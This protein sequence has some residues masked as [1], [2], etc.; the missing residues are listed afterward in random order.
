VRLLHTADWH[1][2]RGFHGA[3]L[4]DAHAAVLDHLIAVADAERPDAIVV[5]GDVFDRAYPPL[6]AIELYDDAV[7]RIAELRIPLVITSGNHDSPIRLGMHG[8]V[9]ASAGVHVRTRVSE[10]GK[11]VEVAG[12]LLY[13]L[14]YLDPPLHA[15]ELAAEPTHAAVLGAAMARIAA[16]RARRSTAAPAIAIAHGVVAG[17]R[18]VSEAG[19]G[20]VERPIDVGGVSAVPPAVF[21]GL[22][23]VALGH[24]H[25]PQAIGDH[26]RYSG[27]PLPFGFDE[28]G[29]T[30]SL[31]LVEVA[32]GAPAIAELLPTPQ[33]RAIAR[34]AG[35]LDGLLTDPAHAHA[36]GAW[37]EATLTDR[38]RPRLAMEQ[39]RRRFPHV[40]KIEHRPAVA[41]D[42]A[43]QEAGYGARVR[44]RDAVGIA[45][46]FLTDVRGGVEADAAEVELLRA[47]LEHE[48]RVEARA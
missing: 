10:V 15:R 22:D 33:P 14:P 9:A 17:A 1:L 42:R 20:R 44:G 7:A 46:R 31:A 6:D 19:T 34:L 25:R 41:V 30:K 21:A 23:Y 12:A 5:A 36:E 48:A 24:L 16:D 18:P 47:A 29:E 45:T 37:V 32:V 39:L 11:P 40:L 27:A 2:G 38:L 35:T 43:D 13:P 3:S 8:R 4:M 28:T 26:L